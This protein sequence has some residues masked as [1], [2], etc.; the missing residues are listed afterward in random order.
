MSDKPTRLFSYG[1]L[2]TMLLAGGCGI[3]FHLYRQ[4]YENGRLTALDWWLS[5]FMLLF[6]GAICTVIVWW[7]NR[8]D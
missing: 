2:V 4:Y 5:G 3:G 1:R 7:A 8:R 6:F